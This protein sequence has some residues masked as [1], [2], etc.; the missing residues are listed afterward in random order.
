[1]VNEMSNST[2]WEE[3]TV[4]AEVVK[5][6]TSKF[7]ISR[8][9]PKRKTETSPQAKP[10]ITIRE[11]YCS[12]YNPNWLPAKSGITLPQGDIALLAINA[13]LEANA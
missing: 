3:E 6:D 13:L 11:W 12:K 5:N 1:M 8:C 9:I 7:V 2:Y 10:V 4:I